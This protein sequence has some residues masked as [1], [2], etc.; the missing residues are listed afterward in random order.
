MVL[1]GG[2]PG[3]SESRF[4]AAGAPCS[5]IMGA[6]TP[7]SALG[8]TILGYIAPWP[9]QTSQAPV[10]L[11][12]IARGRSSEH[13]GHIV[14]PCPCPTP[15]WTRGPGPSVDGNVVNGLLPP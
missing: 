6:E 15:S 14:K 11:T 3:A 9:S 2:D 5:A 12:K 7:L 13:G 1:P 8:P 10:P 4:S